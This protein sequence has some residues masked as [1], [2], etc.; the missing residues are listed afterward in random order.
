MAELRLGGVGHGELSWLPPIRRDPPKSPCYTERIDDRVISLPGPPEVAGNVA[1]N[2]YG[3]TAAD[4]H[5][6]EPP[7][8]GIVEGHPCAVVRA[9]GIIRFGPDIDELKV[10]LGEVAEDEPVLPHHH[11]TLRVRCEDQVEICQL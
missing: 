2:G 6:L 4:R 8:G 3:A 7:T 9:D 1:E 11:E 10:E 5:S